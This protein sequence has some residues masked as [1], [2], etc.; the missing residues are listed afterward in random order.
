MQHEHSFRKI[1]RRDLVQALRAILTNPLTVELLVDGVGSGLPWMER[2]PKLAEPHVIL[3]AAQRARA[4]SGSERGRLVEEEQLS[5]LPWLGE[6]LAVPP[7]EL[8]PT[9]DPTLAVEAPTNPALIIVEA[10]AV[11]VDEAA[12]GMRDQ[13]AARRDPV[14]ARHL[15]LK[16]R[17]AA[18][19]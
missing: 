9:R 6:G 17:A 5:E 11:A 19:L 12:R 1:L 7:A 2:A 3:A 16:T 18:D 14:T 15:T 13:L 8:E 10:S 4:V